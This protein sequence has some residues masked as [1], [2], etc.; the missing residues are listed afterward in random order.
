MPRRRRHIE[1]GTIYHVL[2]RG[3]GRRN[4]FTKDADF[5]AFIKVIREAIDRFPVDLLSYCLMNNHWHLLLRPRKADALSRMMAWLT[6]THARR[7]H[8]HYPN[9]GSGHLYQGRF[10]GF[11]VESDN[12]F[13]VVARYMHANPLR[14]GVVNRAEEWPWSDVTSGAR[15][16]PRAK[17]PVDRPSGWVRIVNEQMPDAQQ[18]A[19]ET[20]ISRGTPFGS[21]RWARR[22]ASRHDLETTLRPRGRPKK[23]IDSL[24]PRYRKALERLAARAAKADKST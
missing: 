12:H 17:W 15:L 2:N 3:N 4:L 11:P 19:I 13:L 10:K 23:P 6:V 7:H 20:S 24:T 18:K 9:P 16:L 1:A 5:D 22:I 8:Q 21:D 14:A